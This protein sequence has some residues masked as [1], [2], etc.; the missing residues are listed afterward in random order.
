[1]HVR[2]PGT[3]GEKLSPYLVPF[4]LPNMIYQDKIKDYPG[5]GFWWKD[6]VK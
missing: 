4:H 5:K 1:M 3:E 2:G 6:L